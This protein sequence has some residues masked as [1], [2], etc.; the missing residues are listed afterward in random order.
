MP[1]AREILAIVTVTPAEDGTPDHLEQCDPGHNGGASRGL[2]S[3]L[4]QSDYRGFFFALP[5][6]P[7]P[8]SPRPGWPFGAPP[9]RQRLLNPI[10]STRPGPGHPEA[11]GNPVGDLRR[12]QGCLREGDP[13]VQGRLEETDRPGC[14]DQEQLRRLRLP[15]PGR[16]RRTGG[17]CGGP[18]P[19]GRHHQASGVGPDQAGLG[20]G[21]SQQRDLHQFHRGLLRAQGQ[22]QEDQ[23]LE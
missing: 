6:P 9:G 19:C 4:T 13:T 16:D 5:A 23:R 14:G 15:D 2:G 12:H 18:G 7:S 17:R 11:T 22:S 21:E 1:E 8:H 20:K 3:I 10:G